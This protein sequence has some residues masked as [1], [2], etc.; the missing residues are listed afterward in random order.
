MAELEVLI[1]LIAVAFTAGI[2]RGFAVCTMTCGPALASYVATEYDRGWLNGLRAGL[3]FNVPRIGLIT[4]VGAILG[5]LSGILISPLFEESLVNLFVFGYIVFAFYVIFLGL[6][7]Y[8][9]TKEHNHR[10]LH[11]ALTRINNYYSN[12]N[13]VLI[14]MGLLLGAV[15]LLEVSIFDAL[16]LSTASGI[17]G[18]SV[19]IPTMIT[20]ALTM[21]IFGLGSMVPL[22]FITIGSG[23]LSTF[24]P[25]RSILNKA[26]SILGITLILVGIF[27]I[28]F[29]VP[30]I[31]VMIQ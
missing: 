3:I 30:A 21:F 12:R 10:P 24:I 17:F 14:L 25:D 18:A 29:R 8:S 1:E 11:R 26:R 15:C 22:L 16:I 31:L 5:Y 20:G 9:K 2:T 23:G 28:F 13:G 7:M 19:G 27:I 4:V 6:S